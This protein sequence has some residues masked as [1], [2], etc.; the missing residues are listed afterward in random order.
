[1]TWTIL[2]GAGTL[3]ISLALSYAWWIRVRIINFRQDVFDVRDDLFV[4]AMELHA[5][6]DSAYRATRDHLNKVAASADHA[7]ISVIAYLMHKG[8]TGSLKDRTRTSNEAL[9]VAID[10]AIEATA[11][12]L[13]HLLVYETATGWLVMVMSTPARLH[14]VAFEQTVRWTRRWILSDESEQ[15]GSIHNSGQGARAA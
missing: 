4:R 7:T 15:V 3:M 10:D 12:R 2:I 13:A 5:F 11:T 14:K 1:M 9:Q 6:E 8:L